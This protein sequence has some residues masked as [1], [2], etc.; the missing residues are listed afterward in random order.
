[1]RLRSR[2][3]S[4]RIGSMPFRIRKC[5]AARLD[6]CAREPAPSVTLT[7]V[8]RPRS[9]S[10]WSMNSAGSL[11]TGGGGPAGAPEKA[12]PPGALLLAFPAVRRAFPLGQTHVL[13]R[14]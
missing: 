13:L 3:V 5:E 1:M 2:Q 14:P 7:A 12:A 8:A 11:E 10:A 9:A 6:K 4:C